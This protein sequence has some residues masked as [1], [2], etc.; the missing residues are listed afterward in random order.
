MVATINVG[1]NNGI[2]VTVTDPVTNTTSNLLYSD[3]YTGNDCYNNNPHVHADPSI[4]AIN[5]AFQKEMRYLDSKK[6]LLGLKGFDPVIKSAYNL[7]GD[8][9][10]SRLQQYKQNIISCHSQFIETKSWAKTTTRTSLE[11]DLIA[12]NTTNEN[13]DVYLF[14]ESSMDLSED[15]VDANN[16]KITP[17]DMAC[18][19]NTILDPLKR[20][21]LHPNAEHFPDVGVLL[22]FDN[23]FLADFLGFHKCSNVSSILTKKVHK[24]IKNEDRYIYDYS[25]NISYSPPIVE[26]NGIII[27]PNNLDNQR[28][29]NYHTNHQS[30]INKY[31]IG[32]ETKKLIIQSTNSKNTDTENKQHVVQIKEMGDVL[33]VFTMLVWMM[34]TN[35]VF[36]ASLDNFK[37]TFLMTTIDGIV[38]ILCI[39]FKLP[40]IVYEF[41]DDDVII[42]INHDITKKK[43]NNGRTRYL[44]RYR[45][46]VLSDEEKKHLIL[47]EILNHNNKIKSRIEIEVKN[48]INGVFISKTENVYLPHT[49][50]DKLINIIDYLNYCATEIVNDNNISNLRAY[51]GNIRYT[52]NN[53]NNIEMGNDVTTN[54]TTTNDTTTNVTANDVI[55]SDNATATTTTRTTA[56]TTTTTIATMISFDT[57]I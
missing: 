3:I 24:S 18:F 32:N 5:P 51:D 35:F 55:T 46:A 14:R 38:F 41:K 37:K 47:T 25:Y 31:V 57:L 16:R 20:S 56:G 30:I 29:E 45:P 13:S 2:T 11:V 50:L 10:Y 36:Q 7:T 40:C 33:Q 17:K 21:F 27:Y 6:D 54:D 43:P 49:F 53:E 1:Y 19:S 9:P 39:M 48:S 8:I 52:T 22:N 12:L 42:D 34:Y 15:I 23:T 44:Q 4:N 28:D 26:I